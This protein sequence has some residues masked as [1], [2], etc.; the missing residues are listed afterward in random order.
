MLIQVVHHYGG[1]GR[2]AKFQ[3]DTHTASIR[4]VPD[5]RYAL[6][7]PRLDQL[8]YPLNK[9]GL[10]YLEGDL[11]EDDAL[12]ILSWNV[13]NLASRLDNNT[14]SPRSVGVAYPLVSPD[15]GTCREVR[16]LDVLHQLFDAGVWVPDE[17]HN[18]V[19]NFG[20]I[21]RRDVGSHSDRD[22]GCA[23]NQ[24]IWKTRW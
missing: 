19:A 14:S 1:R 21:V 15:V 12:A 7:S 20:Y 10:I 17:V 2:S 16:T 13:L 11:G 8:R 18:R 23:V 22:A 24:Q 5:F 6:D 9:R 4:F 3:H